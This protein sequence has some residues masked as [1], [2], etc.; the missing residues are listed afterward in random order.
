MSSDEPRALHF[1]RHQLAID[2]PQA[3]LDTLAGLAGDELD[4]A[5]YWAI[6][7]EALL[8][9]D[10]SADAAEAAR[11]GLERDPED[12]EL[13]DALAISELAQDNLTQADNALRTALEL[14]PENPI[15]LSHRA[16]VLANDERFD[17]ART[18]VAEA[19]RVDPESVPV[20]RVRAQVA[21]LADDT[22]AP[23]YV[24]DLLRIAP[25]DQ[26]AH[27]LRGNLAIRRKRFGHAARA[28]GEA[29]RLDPRDAEIAEVARE[30]RV[31]AHPMLAPV[32]PMWRF[33]RWRS[34]AL[35]L[36]IVFVLAAARL[37]TLRVVVGLV[38][39][40]IVILSW[41]GPRI[42][43]WREKRKYGAF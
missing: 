17:E 8:A 28:F 5:E 29:A 27:A 35:Y 37:Q 43:R 38:W 31:A 11:R 10:R 34:Y 15:L 22:D 42:L 20:L 2:R 40:S 4:D 25:E 24:D 9:L 23:Q 26:I 7:A 41:F 6:R 3:A 33:G 30:A 36:S 13:L 39:L 19:M 12:I 21:V 32:R 14:S 18:A 1:A 16:L